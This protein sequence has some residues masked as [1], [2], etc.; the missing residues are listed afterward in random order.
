MVSVETPAATYDVDDLQPAAAIA[1]ELGVVRTSI[2]TWA[3]RYADFPA[4]VIE[5]PGVR[6]WSLA[7][8]RAWHEATS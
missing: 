8:V 1:A 5:R 6:L 7:E 2:T 3:R 4:A